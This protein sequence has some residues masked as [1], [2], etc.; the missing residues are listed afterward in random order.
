MPKSQIDQNWPEPI[1]NGSKM[2]DFYK[3]HIIEHI[4]EYII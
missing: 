1:T 3:A 2:N 4:I